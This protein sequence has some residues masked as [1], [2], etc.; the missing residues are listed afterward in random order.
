MEQ[1]PKDPHIAITYFHSQTLTEELKRN[2]DSLVPRFVLAFSILVLFSVLCNMSMCDGSFYIDWVVSKPLLGFF[3][4]VNAGMGIATAVGGL[5][6]LSFP[7]NDIVGVM[8]F[9]VVG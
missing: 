7:F 6:L 1:Y 8:P 4:V 3:G 5:S 2:A 9:L